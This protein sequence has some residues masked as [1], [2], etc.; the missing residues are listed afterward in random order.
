MLL[1][2]F[3]G[4]TPKF[5]QSFN[6]METVA[7]GAALQA[8]ILSGAIGDLGEDILLL[9][10]AGRSFCLE[11]VKVQEMMCVALFCGWMSGQ[12]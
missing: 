3:R 1:E 6:P 10:V 7:R 9:D 4:T 11:I 5:S 2:I 12:V 8:A